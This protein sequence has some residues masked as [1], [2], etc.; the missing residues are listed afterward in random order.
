MAGLEV[1]REWKTARWLGGGPWS[2]RNGAL[3]I[4]MKAGVKRLGGWV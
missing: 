1:A 4:D 2:W 3:W